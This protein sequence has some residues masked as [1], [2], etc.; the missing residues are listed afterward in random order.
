MAQAHAGRAAFCAADPVVR[1]HAEGG[2]TPGDV[3]AAREGRD[4][5]SADGDQT[6]YKPGSVPPDARCAGR[7]GHSSGPTLAGRFSRP[8][9]TP[10]ADDGPT[11]PK[12]DSLAGRGIPIR[13]CSWRGLPCRPCHQARGALLP[14]PFT[15]TGADAGGLLSVALSLG[16]PPAGVTRRHV[17]VEPGL[18]S[19]ALARAR[20]RPAV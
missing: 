9:R 2:R 11:R 18:S 17:V 19:N 13:S 15:L 7:D 1:G 12:D 20:D 5:I 3:V 16:S 4:P 14:H 6:A 8:T 10:Q